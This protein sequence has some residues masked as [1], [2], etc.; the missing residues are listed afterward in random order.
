MKTEICKNCEKLEEEHSYCAEGKLT[1]EGYYCEDGKKFE[2]VDEV[3]KEV[4]DDFIKKGLKKLEKQKGCGKFVKK[5]KDHFYYCGDVDGE[6][7]CPKCEPKETLVPLKQKGCGK[8]YRYFNGANYQ[9][10]YC[11][12]DG[13]CP[14][15]KPRNRFEGKIKCP[16][17]KETWSVCKCEKPK[18]HSPEDKWLAVDTSGT[19][20]QQDED[21]CTKDG[22]NV[23]FCLMHKQTKIGTFNLSEKRKALYKQFIA[24]KPVKQKE[25]LNLIFSIIE[26]QDEEFIQRLKVYVDEC[27]DCPD[28]CEGCLSDILNFIDKLAGKELVE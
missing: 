28:K 24:G 3:P 15:C 17:C 18:N 22:C 19:N 27:H 21:I 10:N 4:I 9:K 14:K 12:I 7:L 23:K 16:N 26:Q 8:G 5:T 25:T 1:K 20:S 11:G 2:A 6:L 13:L